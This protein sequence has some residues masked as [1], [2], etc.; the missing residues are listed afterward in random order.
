MSTPTRWVCPLTA[1]VV[2]VVQG[3]QIYYCE[4][5]NGELLEQVAYAGGGWCKDV[6]VTVDGGLVAAGWDN[7][8]DLG[9]FHAKGKDS[10]FPFQC[11]S[12]SRGVRS[13]LAGWE[14]YVCKKGVER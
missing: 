3:G 4:G 6:A 10:L 11:E 14:S 7:Q 1:T 9:H 13:E 2:Y 8:D 12:D 5:P